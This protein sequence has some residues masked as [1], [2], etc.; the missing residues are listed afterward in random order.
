MVSGARYFYLR[1]CLKSMFGV[2]SNGL[3]A[4]TKRFFSCIAKATEEKNDEVFGSQ[5]II[6]R[7]EDTF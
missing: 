1:S 3:R 6:R 5:C 2:E 7:P 4:K